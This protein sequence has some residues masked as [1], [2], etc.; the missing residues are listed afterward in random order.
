MEVVVFSLLHIY[1][2]T[3]RHIPENFNLYYFGPLY[4]PV[5]NCQHCYQ[6]LSSIKGG[7]FLDYLS[8][9]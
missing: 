6:S 3:Q 2:T 8:D 4:G 1:Q 5:A 9:Y 7:E